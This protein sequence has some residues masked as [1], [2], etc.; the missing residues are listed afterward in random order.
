M[1]GQVK[2]PRVINHMK[3]A[4]SKIRD[5]K[6][7]VGTFADDVESAKMWID[8]G[9]Q[10]ISISVDTA[11]FLNACRRIVSDIRTS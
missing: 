7:A 9:I 10:Y 11:I 1:P 6:M 8:A 3:E 4:V 5:A 2:D